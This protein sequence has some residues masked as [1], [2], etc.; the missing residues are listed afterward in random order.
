MKKDI[1]IDVTQG[2]SWAALCVMPSLISLGIVGSLPEALAVLKVTF[3]LLLPLILIYFLNYYLL[4]PK[5][6]YP[7]GRRKKW[8]YGVNA[9]LIFALDFRFFFRSGEIPQEVLDTFGIDR[10]WTFYLISVLMAVAWQVIIILL[11]LGVRNI[12]RNQEMRV[13]FERQRRETAEAELVWLKHQ[14]SPHFLFNTLNNISSLTQIDPDQAQERIGQLSDLLRYA[15]YDS[16]AAQVPLAAE[17]A[18]MDNYVDLMAMRCNGQ[19]TVEKDFAVPAEPAEIAPLLFISLVENAFKHG[20]NARYPSFVQ[21][22]MRLETPGPEGK[23]RVVFRCEN[24]LFEKQGT[25]HIGS[26][27][28]LENMR[29]RL[30]LL[31]PGKYTYAQSASEGCWRVEVTI[32]V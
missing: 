30:E 21:L 32:E 13:A 24:S 1:I 9:L 27:I 19:A 7:G 3:Q 11:A 28:G 5:L 17:M 26:G 20:V 29:R 15:L 2:L 14:L 25:D 8:F 10:L 16:E 22:A 18:F 23:R 4:I 6:L 12:R 31:Y